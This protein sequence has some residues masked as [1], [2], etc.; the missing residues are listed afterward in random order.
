MLY[1][2]KEDGGVTMLET[3]KEELYGYYLKGDDV[4][5]SRTFA[6]KCFAILDARVHD[7]MCVAEQKMLQYNVITEE[8]EPVIFRHVPFFYETG[9]LTSLSD[10]ARKAKGHDFLQA[11]GWVYERNKHLFTDQDQELYQRRNA[12]L[13]EKLYL[14]CGPYNDTSQHVNFNSRPFLEVGA[15]GLFEKASEEMKR[16]KTPEELAFLESVC[17]GMLALRRMAERFSEKAKAMLETETDENC[18][19]NLSLIASTACRVPWEAPKTFYEALATLA[20]LRTATGSLEGAGPNTFGRIDK[21]LIGFY[22]KDIEDGILTWDEAYDLVASFLLIWDCHYDHGMV[23]AGY[24]DH[25]LENT[26]TLG[27][28]D[29]EGLPL[30]NEVTKLFLRVAREEK[31]IFPKIKCRFSANSPKEYL[32]EINTPIIRGTSTVLLQNDDASIPA[33]LR[34]GRPI[35]EA[36]DYY[37][38]G[39]W[40]ISTNQEKYDHGSY[41]N[42]LK[43][44]EFALHRLDHKMEKVGM[45]FSP[46]DGCKSFEEFYRIV[47][48]NSRVLLHERLEITRRGGQVFSKVDHFPIFSATW[49]CCLENHRD[50]TANGAKYRDDYLLMFG[51]PNIVDSLLAIK[52]LV[53]DR[54]KYT[55]QE[56]LGAVRADWQGFENMRL[57]AIRCCGWGDGSEASMSLAGRF[58]DDLFALCQ[59]ESGSYGG[60]VHMG[61][62]TYT[63]IRWWGAETLA[64]PDGR[65]SGDYFSQ[66]LTPSRLKRIPCVN[67]VIN[68]MAA[69]D[70][71]KMAANS[72]VNVILP[73][74]IPLDRCEGFLRAVAATGVQSLQLNCTSREQL[75]DAQ[76]HPEQYPDL[77][78]RVTGFSARFTSLSREWQQEVLTRNFYE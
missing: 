73:A 43:P 61:H 3:M 42:L 36:R 6:E 60:R 29:D 17:C 46:F 20:F 14:I 40:G 64:T 31:I 66:G 26:Y 12:Q 50:Y 53:F 51:F 35:E 71:S 65:K 48:E 49:D 62:L 74:N 15:K 70:P 25:E 54:K 47:L 2:R 1:S 68:S 8:F 27:G 18:R 41:L 33:L 23:M 39:C 19:K 10:G 67:D 7:G 4:D 38:T 13:E 69:L 37:V 45:R 22:R 55:L 52:T 76:K 21:D 63:E 28:C 11:N 58:Y 5:R 16:A 56:Y 30:Y 9:F 24:A 32:D 72:V 78:V 75:L 44:F 34:A 77:I 57:E 59:A